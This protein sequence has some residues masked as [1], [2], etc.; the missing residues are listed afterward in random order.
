MQPW[1]S[2]LLI[3]LTLS[4]FF[5]GAYYQ[6]IRDE[7]EAPLTLSYEDDFSVPTPEDPSDPV[8]VPKA[9]KLEQL[10]DSDNWAEHRVLLLVE[11]GTPSLTSL[12]SDA[13]ESPLFLDKLVALLEQNPT[14]KE[15][16][17]SPFQSNAFKQNESQIL[18]ALF[19]TRS[20]SSRR[21]GIYLVCR[22]H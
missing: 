9:S 17:L 19:S 2:V 3:V 7:S 13:L 21:D 5:Y 11:N 10:A 14:A 4:L 18:R 1:H 6:E 16:I 22:G 8:L 20:A 12:H 15:I